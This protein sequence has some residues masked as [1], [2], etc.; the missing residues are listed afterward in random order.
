M[1]DTKH[2]FKSGATSSGNKPPYECLTL[3]FLRRCAM[4]M[5][6][7][8]HYGKHNWM[9]G[10]QDKEFVLDRLNHAQEHL[11]KL[12]KQIDFGFVMNDD[13]AAA[14]CVNIMMAMEYQEAQGKD[15]PDTVIKLR[16]MKNIQDSEK[17]EHSEYHNKPDFPPNRRI[18]Q[19]EIN[20]PP[21]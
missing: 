2:D 17:L 12:Q 21:S 20:D 18:K 7:G 19:G 8:M 11:S 4:R 3:T 16:E 14:I 1:D 9:L 13:D 6:L 10:V 15:V 5:K